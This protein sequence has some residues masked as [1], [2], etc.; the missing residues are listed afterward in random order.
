MHR[1]AA[2]FLL[3]MS[4]AT[5]ATAQGVTAS[6]ATYGP[7]GVNDLDGDLPTSGE[8]RVTVPAST[9][10]AIEPFASVWSRRRG[11]EGLFGVQLR[12]RKARVLGFGFLQAGDV[13]LRAREPLEKVRQAHFQ[14]GHIPGGEAQ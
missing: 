4:L 6:V 13:G 9:R 11:T 10:L 5:G 14:R 1:T 8:L 7:F 2:Q 3:A 12:Q